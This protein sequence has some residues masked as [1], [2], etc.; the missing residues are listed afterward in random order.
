MGPTEIFKDILDENLLEYE[1]KEDYE[2]LIRYKYNDYQNLQVRIEYPRKI[3][4]TNKDTKISE[5]II[6]NYFEQA[7]KETIKCTRKY[8]STGNSENIN[9]YHLV[10]QVKQSVFKNKD[11]RKHIQDRFDILLRKEKERFKEIDDLLVI[12]LHKI[13]EEQIYENSLNNKEYNTNKYDTIN[14]KLKKKNEYI[15]KGKENNKR[16]YYL[17]PK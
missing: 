3:Y 15:T 16:F 7:T 12:L 8:I 11:D 4:L 14:V 17:T 6:D 2:K 9:E 13:T 10:F 5:I 1:K